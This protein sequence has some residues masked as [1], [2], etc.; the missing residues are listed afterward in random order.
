MKTSTENSRLAIS[1][2]RRIVNFVFVYMKH[3]R[4]YNKHSIYKYSQSQPTH[5]LRT[6]LSRDN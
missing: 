1:S 3:P 4:W 6:I 2:Y 5:T